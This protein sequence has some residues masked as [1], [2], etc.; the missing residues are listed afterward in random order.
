MVGADGGIDAV[1][2]LPDA[3][4]LR[5]FQQRAFVV[6]RII[7]IGGTFIVQLLQPGI[8]RR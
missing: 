8:W 3:F 7:V 1:F 4:A 2:R 6:A 5:K